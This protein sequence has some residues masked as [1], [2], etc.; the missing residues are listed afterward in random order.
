M[1]AIDIIMLKLC[2]AILMYPFT[3]F[4]L[5][6]IYGCVLDLQKFYQCNG[7]GK[8]LQIMLLKNHM[9]TCM[10]LK[11]LFYNCIEELFYI[12]EYLII[13]LYAV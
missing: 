7:Y 10:V 8:T 12:L 9:F 4:N 6:L 1:H 13:F 11:S 2:G 3:S 5:S